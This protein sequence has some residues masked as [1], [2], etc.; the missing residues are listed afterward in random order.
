MISHDVHEHIRFEWFGN[1][2][3]AILSI[4]QVKETRQF[5]ESITLA[6][7][8]TSLPITD[9]P[10]NTELLQYFSMKWKDQSIILIGGDF[11]EE[12]PK[13]LPYTHIHISELSQ[14]SKYSLNASL[15]SVSNIHEFHQLL[16]G[17]Q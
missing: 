9:I 11:L 1:E 7:N 15:P 16:K 10:Y 14:S 13:I 8:A 6:R 4:H 17:A 12:L 2:I 5:L 3:D